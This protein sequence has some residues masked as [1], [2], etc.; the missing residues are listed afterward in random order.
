[1]WKMNV[2]VEVATRIF[3]KQGLK[4][5]LTF[6]HIISSWTFRTSAHRPALLQLNQWPA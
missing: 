3:E 6:F 1:M 4:H 2:K 5:G